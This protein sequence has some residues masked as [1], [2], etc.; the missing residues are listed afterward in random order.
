M[1]G[2]IVMKS[3]LAF[4]SLLIPAFLASCSRERQAGTSDDTLHFQVRGIVREIE[5]DDDSLRIEHEDIPGYMPSMTMPFNVRD[6]SEIDGL[7][8]GDAISFKFVVTGDR[9]WI[10]DVHPVDRAS[11]RLPEKSTPVPV[12]R[13]RPPHVEEGDALPGFKL[14]DQQG[15]TID[16]ETFEG[17]ALVLTFIFTRCAVPDFCPLMSRN[18]ETIEDRIQQD[19]H[20]ASKVRL[21]SVSFDHEFDTPEVL[22]GY[23]ARFSDNDDLW[24]FASGDSEEIDRL[25]GA[26]RVFT[27]SERGTID[28]SLCTALVD[29]DGTIRHIWR[30]NFWKPDE[31]VTALREVVAADAPDAAGTL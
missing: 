1:P 23:A 5:A 22:A 9:S 2:P 21:L 17:R 19:P 10:E 28:H 12:S 20:L 15:R 11:V 27:R 30:G 13:N 29:A 24:R 7:K 6:A 18:F 26:F 8:P 3:L 25:T 31:V 4:A 16:N 14:T